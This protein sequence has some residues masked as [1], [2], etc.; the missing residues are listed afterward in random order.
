M[1]QHGS[2][3]GKY[4][5]VAKKTAI[6]DGPCMLPLGTFYA[7]FRGVPTRT[8]HRVQGSNMVQSNPF[9]PRSLSLTRTTIA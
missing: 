3:L 9:I 1:W 2:I 4:C 6:T 7:K 8:L 5:A